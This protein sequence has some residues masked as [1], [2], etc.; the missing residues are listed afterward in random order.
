MSN[1]SGILGIVFG[2]TAIGVVIKLHNYNKNESLKTLLVKQPITVLSGE[3]FG[4]K[5]KKNKNKKNKK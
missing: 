2:L 4:G 3:Y 1:L 5:T